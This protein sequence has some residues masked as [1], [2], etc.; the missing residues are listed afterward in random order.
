MSAIYTKILYFSYSTI[1][2]FMMCVLILL[3][4]LYNYSNN[5]IYIIKYFYTL[6]FMSKNIL[7]LPTDLDANILPTDIK[8][9]EYFSIDGINY[10]LEEIPSLDLQ[11]IDS[12]KEN[13]TLK[14]CKKYFRIRKM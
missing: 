10:V 6:S 9:N 4:K 12:S 5:H 2:Y 3:K 14:D 7:M 13:C 1:L 8:I 11:V